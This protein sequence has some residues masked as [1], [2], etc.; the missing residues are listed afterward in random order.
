[1]LWPSGEEAGAVG[2]GV[3]M[4]G[5]TV[6]DDESLMEEPTKGSVVLLDESEPAITLP[7]GVATIIDTLEQNG[8][9][10]YAVGG[11]VRD[12]ILGRTPEDW[13]ITTNALPEEAKS[14]FRKTFDTGIKHGTIT[15]RMSGKS[16]ELTT[17][18]VDGEYSDGRHPDEVRFVSNLREDLR[19]RDFTINAMAYHPA[20]GLIDL[21]GGKEDLGKRRIRCVGEARERFSEDA[22]RMLRALRFSAQLD[23]EIEAETAEAICVLHANIRQVSAERVRMELEKLLC[24]PHPER[25]LEAAEL[26][27]TGEFLP[28]WDAMLATE[29]HSVHH[30][31][32]VG[33][34]TLVVV[35]ACP[36]NNK[37]LRLAGLLHDVAKPVTKKTDKKG[38]D[39]FVGHPF[40]GERMAAGILRR[41]KY[42]NRTIQEVS[43]LVRFHDERLVPGE[44]NA[45][46]LAA[47]IGAEHMD[48]LLVLK[49]ADLEGQSDYNK[50]E[51]RARLD[52]LEADFSRCRERGDALSMRELAIDG[53][54][55]IHLGAKRGPQIGELLGQL[56][57]EVVDEPE[58]NC[59]EYLEK[60]AK[61]LMR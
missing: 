49:R 31:L 14:L 45:R 10:A 32:D 48:A 38:V 6:M 27:L 28:E 26:G 1:M 50:E 12:S 2:Q 13:D 40:V 44:R 5:S 22:L 29:Q 30:H 4:D 53:Q 9:E 34:H 21:F 3:L 56:F 59:L 15:V 20:H 33:R 55:L 19:R 57:E 25:L 46:R 43:R 8:F 47:R 60:R 42:D 18:R 23:F 37:T 7:D 17:Y 36:L 54:R 61:E 58:K 41:L 39:H 11:C 16:Y 52:R 35:Q 51:K 24:S